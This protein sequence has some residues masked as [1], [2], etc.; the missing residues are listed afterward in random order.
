MDTPLLSMK[1]I[2][3]TFGSM[4]AVDHVD[5]EIR[6]GRIH[7]LLGENGAGKSTLMN[8]LFGLLRPDGGSVE[9]DGQIVEVTS[10]KRA[11]EL[12]IGMVHQHFKLVPSLTVAQNVALGREPHHGPFVDTKATI[13]TVERLSREY[14]LDVKPHDRVR[15]LSV[16]AQ[17][18]VEILRALAQDVRILVLDEPTAVLT[19]AETERFFEV[20]RGFADRGLA[21]ILISHHLSEVRRVADEVTVLRMGSRVAHSEI[22]AVTNAE[23]AALIIGKEQ[24]VHSEVERGTPG[25]V[26]LSVDGLHVR[27][28]RGVDVVNGVSFDVRAGEIVGVLG[29][30]GNGQTELVEAVTGLR[31]PGAGAVV[32]NGTDTTGKHPGK[33]R[34]AGLGHVPEDRQGRGMAGY[35]SVQ[36]NIAIGY[37]DTDDV[38]GRL[39][40]GTRMAALA[41]RLMKEYDVRARTPRQLARRLSGGNAQ[42]MVLARELSR[43]PSIVVCAEPTRGLDIAATAAVRARLVEQRDLGAGVLLVSSEIE[44]VTQIADRVLVISSGRIVAEFADRR[45]TE[46]EVGRAMLGGE[47]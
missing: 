43:R 39:I 7:A 29:I 5:L 45:P 20:V 17:Q 15:S 11:L 9:I 46:S 30:A 13:E 21:V 44:E 32:V 8:C 18:R 25:E 36:D 31:R 6:A 47:E 23:L 34:A 22:G 16:G 4:T 14:G 19:P 40:S 41:Q 12:G 24:E 28:S 26:R 42:K 38:G 2:V 33:V 3:K 27:D 37:L 10:P 35:W 1:G